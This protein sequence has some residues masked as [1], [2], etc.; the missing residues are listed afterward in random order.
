VLLAQV[1]ALKAERDEVRL[2]AQAE[3]MQRQF[4]RWKKPT[5]LRTSRERRPDVASRQL[6]YARHALRRELLAA[7]QAAQ[8]Q[9]RPVEDCPAR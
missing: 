2:K 9:V 4:D 1:A 5:H 7:S 6:N 3:A 8:T